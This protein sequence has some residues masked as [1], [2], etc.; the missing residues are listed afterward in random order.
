MFR[1]RTK[2]VQAPPAAKRLPPSDTREPA[3]RPHIKD[4]PSRRLKNEVE[5]QH[6]AEVPVTLDGAGQQGVRWAFVGESRLVDQ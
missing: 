4:A 5:Q 2:I 6:T 1:E 3:N